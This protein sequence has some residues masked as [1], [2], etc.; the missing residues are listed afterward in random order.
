MLT[1]LTARSVDKLWGRW[2]LPPPFE[3]FAAGHRPIGEIWFEH[4]AGLEPD[5]LVKYL[6]TSQTSSIQVHPAAHSARAGGR[7][8]G[9]DEA[10]LPL[11]AEA[12]AVIGM[13]LRSAIG[14]EQLRA[15]ALDGSIADMVD[16]QPA[17]VGEVY[18]SPAGT[19]HALGAGLV[20]LEI[21]QN[22]D[23]TYRLYDYGRDR[24]L[25]LDDGL[26]AA[27]PLKS[28]TKESPLSQSEGREML[29]ARGMFVLERWSGIASAKLNPVELGPIWL[30]PLQGTTFVNDERLEAGSVW[31]VDEAAAISQ[32]CG[33]QLIAAYCGVAVWPDLLA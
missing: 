12:G 1:R 24:P 15:A 13:G 17:A 14:E 31:L 28:V 29:S 16:W 3:N 23:I 6:F 7:E 19:I 8:R 27:N 9:K 4:P 26:A 21:Q 11:Q 20:L 22:A 30:I 32:E 18:Y 25:H 33:A 5:L 2:A 10:W